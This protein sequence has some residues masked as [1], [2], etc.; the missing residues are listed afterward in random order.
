VLDRQQ[1]D[2]PV[3]IDIVKNLAAGRTAPALACLLLPQPWRVKLEP[4]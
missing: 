3:L 4:A 2:V 1:I